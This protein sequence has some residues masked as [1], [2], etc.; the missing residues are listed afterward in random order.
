MQIQLGVAMDLTARRK[1]CSL[2]EL[3]EETGL[4][5]DSLRHKV[6]RGHLPGV[7]KLDRRWF[8]DRQAFHEATRVCS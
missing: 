3:S 6:I 2:K 1:Y 4:S 7:H 8:V 5:Y